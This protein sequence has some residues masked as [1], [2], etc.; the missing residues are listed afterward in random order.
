MSSNESV[1]ETR[2]TGCNNVLDQTLHSSSL[3]S[4]AC[5]FYENFMTSSFVFA[6]KT[7]RDTL[8]PALISDEGM[9]S[10][11]IEIAES[12]RAFSIISIA[13]RLE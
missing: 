12:Y 2:T 3:L 11:I 8:F 7:P 4:P 10:F 1:D 13:P 9:G 6:F 5:W